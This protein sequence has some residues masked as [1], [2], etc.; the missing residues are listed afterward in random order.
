M[1]RLL[2]IA[3]IL[4]LSLSIKGQQI[5]HEIDQIFSEWNE[6]V[7]PGGVLTILQKD[8]VVFSKAR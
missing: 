2:I 1:K 4:N 7:Q 3:I 5:E 8:M 6:G